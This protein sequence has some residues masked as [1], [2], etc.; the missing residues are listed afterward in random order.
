MKFH[1][2]DESRNG[3]IGGLLCTALSALGPDIARTAI[4]SAIGAAVSFLVTFLLSKIFKS[5]PN[6]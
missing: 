2:L 3:A 5:N 6:K 1:F 4:I